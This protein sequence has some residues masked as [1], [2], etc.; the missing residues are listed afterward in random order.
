MVA[1]TFIRSPEFLQDNLEEVL[2][3]S[4]NSSGIISIKGSG[5][6]TLIGSTEYL[7]IIFDGVVSGFF[8][9]VTNAVGTSDLS[10]VLFEGGVT[11]VLFEEVASVDSF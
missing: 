2:V 7:R 5:L 6:S 4:S 11:D 10:L 9:E 3:A 8:F 1:S